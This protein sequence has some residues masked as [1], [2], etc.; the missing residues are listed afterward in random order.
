MKATLKL[1]N[2]AGVAVGLH[3][4]VLGVVALLVT[5]V[6]A[7]MATAFPGRPGAVYAAAGVLASVLFLFSLLAH[8][9]AHAIVARRNGVEVDDITLWLLGGVARLR[10]ESP[11][12]GADFRIAFI[13]P[14]VS[15]AAAVVFGLLASLMAWV[16]VGPPWLQVVAYL[17]G[18]NVI[19]AVFNLI[20]AAPLDGGR[21]LRAALW[22]WRGDR[23]GAA[24]WSARAGRAFGLALLAVGV[25]SF[26][27]GHGSGLWWVLLGLFIVVMA[28]AEERQAQVGS[29]LSG[30][31]VRDVMTQDPDTAPG[32]T[33]VE[34]FLQQTALLH[35]HSAFPLLDES[36]RLE[37]LITLNRMKGVDADHRADTRLRDVACPPDEV[38]RTEP[39]EPLADLMPRLG[40][41]TDG[42]ALVFSDGR[43]VGIVSPSDV[44]RAVSL[45]GLGVEAEAFSGRT[46]PKLGE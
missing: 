3:W 10:G 31:R 2:V 14:V 21:V 38:P 15:M 45:R 24:V 8:E 11:T 26:L 25:L 18:I 39:D 16:G 33:N 7:G 40:G 43:L 20:P 4:S 30:L 37:G 19:L 13:G 9:V 5:V 35:R 1:G 34:Q 42:R 28:G 44:S 29:A 32:E 27:F 22:A 6:S 41:C 46:A 23:T 17:A 12:P 36:G